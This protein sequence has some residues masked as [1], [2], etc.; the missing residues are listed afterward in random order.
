MFFRV[1]STL[2]RIRLL[3][4]IW[5]IKVSRNYPGN[6]SLSKRR[7]FRIAAKHCKY[8]VM[9]KKTVPLLFDVFVYNI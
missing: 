7:I 1:D 4:R 5:K 6:E 3:P 8:R 9:E 2:T